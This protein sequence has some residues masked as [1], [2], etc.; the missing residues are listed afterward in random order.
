[1]K[2]HWLSNNSKFISGGD[3]KKY[4]TLFENIPDGVVIANFARKVVDVNP[5]ACELFGYAKEEFLKLSVNQLHPA[6]SVAEVMHAFRQIVKDKLNGVIEIEILTKDDRIKLVSLNFSRIKFGSQVFLMGIFRDITANREMANRYSILAEAAQD[7]IYIIDQNLVVTY[8]NNF[9]SKLFN[10]T[11]EKIVG[12]NIKALFP[13]KVYRQQAKSVNQ[14]LKTGRPFYSE[15]LTILPSGQYWLSNQLVPIKDNQSR[16]RSVMGFSRNITTSKLIQIELQK[17]YSL[18]DSMMQA[19]NDGTLVIDLLGKVIFYNK[20]FQQYWSIPDRLVA[21]KD[22]NKLLAFVIKQLKNPKEFLEKVDYLYRHPS[23]KSF[24][25]INF[26][27]GRIFERYSVP[28][29]LD[30]KIVGRVWNFRDITEQRQAQNLLVLSEQKYRRLFEAAKDGI[31]ILDAK[32]GE[33]RE[34]NPYLIDMLGYSHKEFLRKKLWHIGLFKDIVASKKA[35]KVLKDKKY[36]HYENLPLQTKTGQVISVE[37]VS[38]VY[39]IDHLEVIQCNIRDITARHR[40]EMA[41]ADNEARMRAIFENSPIAIVLV[42]LNNKFISA[43]S[44]AVSLWGYS[45]DELQKMTFGDITHPDEVQRDI[46]QVKR[47]VRGEIVVYNVDKRYIR[48]DGKVIYGRASATLIRDGHDRPLH[49]L[50]IIEDITEHK[51]WEKAI[52]ESEKKY[53]NLVEHS[54]DGILVI[55]DGLVKFANKTI[56][57]MTGYVL[58]EVENKSMLDF[59]SAKSQAIVANNY[60]LRM[61][62][63]PSASRYEFELVKKDGQSIV[64]ET[65]SSVIDFEGRLAVLAIIRDVSRAKIVDQMKSEFVSM[66][67]HQLRTPLTGIKWFSELLLKDKTEH[68]SAKQKDF[69]QQIYSSNERMIKLVGDLLDVSHIES[70]RKFNIIKKPNDLCRA[71]A[72]S[73]KE[74]ALL[75]KKKNISIKL[76]KPFSRPIMSNFD[77]EKIVQLLNNLISNAIKYSSNNS[78]INIDCKKRNDFWEV[79][80]IDTGYGIPE[81]Q[82]NKIFERFFRGDNIRT[83]SPEG[84][85]LGLYIARGI[86]EGHGGKIWLK[87]KE[88]A[89]TTV[90]FTLPIK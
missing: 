8:V 72:E 66:S 49:F 61:K 48:K 18:L 55:Q 42:D 34:V 5:A 36:V 21:Q 84:T 35:F 40:A 32:T 19:S 27:D 57:D 83:V 52:S 63:L 54:N 28:Q 85:G 80:I 90:Y 58:A 33:I 11:P 51:K 56:Q 62:G 76:S 65:N 39:A 16:V 45:E 22:D 73:M 4:L 7:S 70:G 47:L 87:S 23:K 71:M 43:N 81:N 67:S 3:D 9:G 6:R 82:Q 1:M 53:N 12:K 50:T 86:V 2:N 88:N 13:A 64:V 74:Q 69:L 26:K 89:G 68:L 29:I 77:F 44:A 78:K 24:D 30:E 46:K 31:L 41:L 37:F 79:A 15:K 38:N 59:I 60:Q 10:S 25:Y 14:V 20:L 17:N 75:A